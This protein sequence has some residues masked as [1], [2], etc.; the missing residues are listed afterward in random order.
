MGAKIDGERLGLGA[1]PF[2]G[3]PTIPERIGRD[4][5]YEELQNSPTMQLFLQKHTP[6]DMTPA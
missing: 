4:V 3:V 5:F 2:S 1:N 6:K